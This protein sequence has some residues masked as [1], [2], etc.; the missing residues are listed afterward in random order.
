MKD[1]DTIRPAV[2]ATPLALKRRSFL[3]LAGA[4]LVVTGAGAFTMRTARAG[5]GY[6]LGVL[7]INDMHSRLAEISRHNSTCSDDDSA[8]GNC[9]GGAARLATAIREHRAV[10]DED[11]LPHVTLDAG[12]QSQGTL[13]YTT[14]NGMAEIEMMNMIGFDAMALGNHEFNN[15]PDSLAAMIAEASFPVISGN[16]NVAEGPL[17]DVL[18][19]YTVIERDGERIAVLAVTTPD[20]AFISSPGPHVTFTDDIVYLQEAVDRVRGDGIHKILLLSHVGFG[21]DQQIA[22]EV[23]GISAIIGGHSH[24]LLSNTVEDAPAYAT[25]VESPSGRAV[26]IVQ[27]Y[28]FS[29]Y[30][31]RMDLEFADDGAVVSATGDTILLDASFAEAEDLQA[32]IDELA[33]PI[34]EMVRTPVAELAAGIDGSRE[35]CRAMECEMGNTV[36]DAMLEAVDG[37]G[38][39]IA[40]A[41]G[42]GLRASLGEG[43]VTLGDV[44][45][46][47]PFQN[48]AYTLEL[49]GAT[50][51]AALEHGVNAVEDGAGR[52]P[53]VAGLRFRLDPSVA[54]N[55]GRVSE[56]EVRDGD[57]WAP[58]DPDATYGVVTNNF[59]A[60]GGDGYAMLATEGMNGYDTAIDLSEMLAEY[61]SANEPFA[62][63]IDGR[64]LQ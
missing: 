29:R 37:Q 47:L 1:K 33:G 30:L 6:R 14:Y 52:F 25:M 45:T 51:I 53:Q 23:D 21:R 46:V 20:T 9:F 16:T 61:L 32:R 27:A 60:G 64:I 43:E 44:L 58:I 41:N 3:T 18:E 36:A 39:T 26:P 5:G 24:T 62:P 40:L 8:D 42:G 10:M 2:A 13:F 4:S 17:G 15:G 35:S 49:T 19:E 55:E 57:G 59:L 56:V 31:G 34:E 28:A 63:V 12:D 38:I 50:L 48:T 7:H 11:G 54:P 22:A